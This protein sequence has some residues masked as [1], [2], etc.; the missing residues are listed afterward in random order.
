[1]NSGIGGAW[2][3]RV[4]ARARAAVDEHCLDDE[5]DHIDGAWF[6]RARAVTTGATTNAGLFVASGGPAARVALDEYG[7]DDERESVV[8]ASSIECARGT[9]LRSRSMVTSS[10]TSGTL[11]RGA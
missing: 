7:R 11:S 1:M 4:P 2:I 8:G 6:A 9:T 5:R 3:H 10:T